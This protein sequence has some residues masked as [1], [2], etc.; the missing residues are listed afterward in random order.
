MDI[1]P[2][3][4]KTSQVIQSY[5]GE[6][7]KVSGVSYSG[8][9][10]IYDDKTLDWSPRTLDTLTISDFDFLKEFTGKPDVFLLGTGKQMRF[11]PRDLKHQ[12]TK[13]NV[14]LEPMDTGAACRTYNTLLA[15]GRKVC[16]CLLIND[17]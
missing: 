10:I 16:A 7:F 12:L 8:S 13:I 5:G 11:I 14:Y 6:G 1:T 17:L 2:L 9:I 15:D 3:I 4:P